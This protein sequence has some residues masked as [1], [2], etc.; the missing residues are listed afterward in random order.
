[1]LADGLYGRSRTWPLHVEDG[2][3]AL[4][5]HALHAWTLKIPHPAGG[6]MSFE[7]PI[8]ADLAHLLPA[9]IRPKTA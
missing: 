7:A 8:P 3:V 4:R 1:V 9:G 5:R 6:E 2:Q